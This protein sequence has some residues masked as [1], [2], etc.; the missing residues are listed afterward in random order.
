[1]AQSPPPGGRRA[2]TITILVV[3]AVAAIYLFN[4]NLLGFLFPDLVGGAQPEATTTAAVASASDDAATTE[5]DATALPAGEAAGEQNELAQSEPKPTEPESTEPEPAEPAQ[6]P[7]ATPVEPAQAQPTP[8]IPPRIHGVPTM[9]FA[10]LP[11]EAHATIALIDAGGPFPYDED[12]SVFQN[13]EGLLPGRPKG[14]YREY[15]VETPGSDDRG[16]RRIVEGGEGELYY[17]D[18]HY[19]SFKYVVRGEAQP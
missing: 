4:T 13:R 9:A 18:D 6:Q 12:G 14:Y 7:A 8:T 1:M 2:S 11:A 16:A 19:E 17:T 15:T 5:P 10:A 3:V